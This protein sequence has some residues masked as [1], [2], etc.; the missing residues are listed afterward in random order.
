MLDICLK[1]DLAKDIHFLVDSGAYSI[2]NS[3]KPPLKVEIY[4]A[5]CL[6]VI[7]K[8]K[9]EFKKLEFINL[10]KIPGERNVPVTQEDIEEAQQVSWKNYLYLKDKVQNVLPVFHQG[11]DFLYLTMIIQILYFDYSILSQIF[12][13]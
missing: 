6:D 13:V 4:E 12:K 9:G 7:K 3:G 8:A 1:N 5:F 11:D 2:W 10:D